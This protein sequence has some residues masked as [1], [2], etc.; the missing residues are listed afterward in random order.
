MRVD[1]EHQRCPNVIQW[2]SASNKKKLTQQRLKQVVKYCPES[3]LFSAIQAISQR[4]YGDILNKSLSS[5]YVV[6]RIDGVLYR[7]HRLA[8]LYMTGKWPN[9]VDHKNLDRSDNRWC[10]LR[11]CS[12]AENLRNQPLKSN[13]KTGYKNVSW[14]EDKKCFR[15]YIVKNYKQINLGHF[16]SAEDAYAAYLSAAKDLHGEFFN[17]TQSKK[18]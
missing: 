15:A 16:K 3:G 7:A 9:K 14:R 17:L 8:F 2:K 6:I 10:N 5:G 12:H 18:I 4:K 13:N 1:P 11:E